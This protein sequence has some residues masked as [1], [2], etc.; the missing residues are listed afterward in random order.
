MGLRKEIELDNGIVLNYHRIVSIQKITN[1]SNLI[2][3]ASY[4]SESQRLKE[5]AYQELQRKKANNEEMTQEEKEEVEK[6]INVM[7]ET[8]YINMDYDENMTIEDAYGYLQEEGFLY[9]ARNA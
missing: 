5:K 6:G 4:I 3:I 7:I 2:E 8:N 9:G 1:Q